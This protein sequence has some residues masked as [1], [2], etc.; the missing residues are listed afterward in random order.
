MINRAYRIIRCIVPGACM[1]YFVSY[2]RHLT[3]VE[4]RFLYLPVRAV[5]S[6]EQF[7]V[8]WQHPNKFHSVLGECGATIY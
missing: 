6:Y 1:C 3:K 7:S 8:V 5:C 4:I 2:V